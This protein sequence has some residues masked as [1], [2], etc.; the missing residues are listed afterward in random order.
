MNNRQENSNLPLPKRR[1]AKTCVIE[2]GER[3]GALS[4]SFVLKTDP[5][6]QCSIADIR[7]TSL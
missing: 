6:L 1:E 5:G 3:Y 4:D 7:F 2:C